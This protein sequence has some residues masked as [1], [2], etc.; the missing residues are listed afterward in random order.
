MKAI[1]PPLV[2]LAQLQARDAH[3]SRHFA[4]RIDE[5]DATIAKSSSR[6][7]QEHVEGQSRRGQ[8][9]EAAS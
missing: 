1:Y 2:S 3:Q 9:D 8:S 4:R 5:V 6:K 7:K